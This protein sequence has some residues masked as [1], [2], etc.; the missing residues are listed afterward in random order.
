[1]RDGVVDQQIVD[2]MTVLTVT[3]ELD[4]LVAAGLRRSLTASATATRPDVVV[5]LRQ[6]TFMDCSAVGALMALYRRVRAAGGC[7][8]LIGAEQGALRLVQLC[9]LDGVLCVHDSLEKA[10]APVC[11][12]HP[13]SALTR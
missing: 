13:P 1:M 12:R 7:L 10:I 9:K 8:R 3:G 11:D 6:V 4:V 5:D 2:G